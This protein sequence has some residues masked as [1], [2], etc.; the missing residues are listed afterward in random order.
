[1]R[2][3]PLQ[4]ASVDLRITRFFLL[5]SFLPYS[6]NMLFFR[7]LVVH[8]FYDSLEHLLIAF[9]P[10]AAPSFLVVHAHTIF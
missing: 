6:L 8:D 2:V 10:V 4:T 9:A 7:A 3:I 1:M 5:F